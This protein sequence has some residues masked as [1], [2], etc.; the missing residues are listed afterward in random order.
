EVHGGGPVAGEQLLHAELGLGE[1]A[2]GSAHVRHALLEQA[3]RL[4]EGDVVGLH[5]GEDHLEPGQAL[6]ESRLLARRLDRGVVVGRTA[7][8][9]VLRVLVH[10]HVSSSGRPAVAASRPSLTCRWKVAPGSKSASVR[11]TRPSRPR[12]NEYP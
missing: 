8:R 10:A 5:A 3:E 2:L 11:R 4:L 7:G 9:L 12:A 1:D 6:L